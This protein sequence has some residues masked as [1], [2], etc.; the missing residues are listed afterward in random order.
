M[1]NISTYRSLL[2]DLSNSLT[3]SD[4]EQLKF[5]CRDVIPAGRAEKITRPFE[6]FSALE[7]LNM[8][9][10]ENRDFLAS[11]L[12][13]VNRNDLRN[14]LLGIQGNQNISQFDQHAA[15][16]VA[17]IGLYNCAVPDTLIHDLVEDLSTSWRMLGRRLG[18]V[19]GVLKNVDSENRRVIDKG[20][21]MFDEWKNRKTT[22]ATMQSLRDGLERIGRRDLSEKVRDFALREQQEHATAAVE[23]GQ[24]HIGTEEE[25]RPFPN[26][27]DLA[28]ALRDYPLT[29]GTQRQPEEQAESYQRPSASSSSVPPVASSHLDPSVSRPMVAPALSVHRPA[30]GYSD[31]HVSPP[32]AVPDQ[33]LPY[34]VP[35][36]QSARDDS[37]PPLPASSAPISTSP[38]HAGQNNPSTDAESA[39]MQADS[40]QVSGPATMGD[41]SGQDITDH[42]TTSNIRTSVPVDS[43]LRSELTVE[44]CFLDPEK[45]EPVKLLGRGGFAKV[46][47]CTE[48]RTGK[49]MA[50]KMCD[51]GVNHSETQKQTQEMTKEVKILSAVKH[52]NIVEFFYTEES[53][54]TLLLFLEY[55]EGGSV[56]DLLISKGPIQEPL[57]RKF[58]LQ[59]LTGVDFL[60]NNKIIHK[61]IKGGN[62][63]LDKNQ[64]NV[65]LADFGISKI[66]TD[67]GTATGSRL[68]KNAAATIQWA[69]PELLA[70]D[71]VGYETDIWSVG[72]TVIEM[73]TA[74]PPL[75]DLLLPQR[76]VKIASIQVEP[77]RDCSSIAYG[78]LKECLSAKDVRP[79]AA[80]LLKED[81]FV[82]FTEEEQSQLAWLF[83]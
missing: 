1:E 24:R 62:V 28:P 6:F 16:E 54:N 33:S 71:K 72:C 26:L 68:T 18:L 13:A 55:M 73:L 17:P 41:I 43:A 77:P 53:H 78:F 21:A 27:N 40:R 37:L 44:G 19:E 8:L 11:K 83:S 23:H 64:M 50:V 69:S 76:I 51:L 20:V 58:T 22:D 80:K 70:C 38:S 32:A 45:Y 25:R 39:T 30:S 4:L 15:V 66:M 67:L 35:V 42:G 79:S 49:Q 63:L 36:S 31:P 10:E 14:K 65:K 2:L 61:D 46:Y 29:T 56:M 59:I 34:P 74:K 81:P 3:S 75:N 48:K 60:H 47:L 9:S 52:V 82:N 7:Q 5:L 12:I 57:V